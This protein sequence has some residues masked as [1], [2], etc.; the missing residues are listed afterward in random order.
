ME[1]SSIVFLF[2]FFPLFLL[3]YFIA[4]K[5]NIRNFIL[6][7]FS[8]VFYAF[9][10]PFYIFVI[11]L[12]IVINFYLTGKLAKN[13][14]KFLFIGLIIFNILFIG[15][16]KYV[17]FIVDLINIVLPN[18]IGTPSIKLPIGISFY[19]FQVLSY[20][21]DVYRHDI[22]PEKNLI[23]FGSYI[24]AFPQLIAGPIVRYET[25]HDEL[26]NR[27]ENIKDFSLGTR[28]FMMGL[29]KKVVIANTLGL[30]ATSIFSETPDIF[31]LTGSWV[32]MIC[33]SLQILFD[34]SG[35]SDMAIGIGLMLGFHYLENFDY[36]YIAK[37]IT[38]FWRRWH[39]SL[40]TFFRDYVYI[41]LGGNRVKMPRFILNILIVWGL[42]GLW[43]G[44]SI[45]FVLWG[46]YF[47]IILLLEKLILKKYFKNTPD[48]IKHI[49]TLLLIIFGWVLFRS[50]SFNEISNIYLAMFGY[51]GIGNMKMFSYLNILNYYNIIAL[52]LGIIL[53][54]KFG[55][56]IKENYPL[57]CDLLIVILFIMAILEIIIGSYNPFI[58]F[59]F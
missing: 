40:G 38:E 9:G 45:N 50:T 44:A 20:V 10:E 29:A 13:H 56:K 34:F 37:S 11:L 58:Y 59:R 7:L 28:R 55:N 24:M 25:I 51:Y 49:Y 48:F 3:T 12:S 30:V 21:I 2:V 42:T 54:I 46:L 22:K 6:F 57:V 39:I 17:P 52:L 53:C 16:F 43:H 32:G 23:Y 36:P 15:V 14:N 19:T 4:K 41:P 35:Y 47:G 18:N 8:I 5:R 33:Y 26:D 31:G 1:F 27:K